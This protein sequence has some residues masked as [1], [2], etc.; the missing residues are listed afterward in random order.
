MLN[1][2]LSF[3]DACCYHFPS[4]SSKISTGISGDKSDK[5]YLITHCAVA[6]TYLLGI[7]GRLALWS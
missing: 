2:F 6:V 4:L 5:V 1:K 7:L 3:D